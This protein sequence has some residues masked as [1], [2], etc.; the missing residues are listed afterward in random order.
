MLPTIVAATMVRI[1]VLPFAYVL[2][3]FQ[4]SDMSRRRLDSISDFARQGF[5]VR[6][7]CLGK[8]CGPIIDWD[9]ADFMQRVLACGGSLQAG[10]L[11][12]QLKCTSCDRRGAQTT[13]AASQTRP[14]FDRPN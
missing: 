2:I 9:A 14:V 3:V 8:S 12:W 4:N 6:I 10:E 5:R 11:E 7:S 1:G 13:T